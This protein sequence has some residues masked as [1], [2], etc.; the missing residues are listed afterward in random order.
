MIFDGGRNDVRLIAAI[1]ELIIFT[2]VMISVSWEAKIELIL[3]VI[4][5]VSYVNYVIGTFIPPTAA[6]YAKGFTGYS[7]ENVKTNFRPDWRGEDFISIF[8]VYFPSITGILAGAGISGELREPNTAIPKGTLL[9]ILCTTLVYLGS[10]WLTG[11]TAV[12]WECIRAS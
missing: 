10:I 12:R 1:T 3:I 4:V 8:S 7:W 5:I 6:Q 9:G 2:I 11:V